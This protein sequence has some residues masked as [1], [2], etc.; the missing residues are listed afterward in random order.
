MAERTHKFYAPVAFGS[1]R[2]TIGH[3]FLTL[4]A[5]EF[6]AIL[7]DFNE[8]G[9]I[10]WGVEKPTIV[11]TDKQAIIQFFSGKAYNSK[12]LELLRPNS[13]VY[14]YFSSRPGN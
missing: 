6:L 4:Y 5:E 3:V 2:F 14:I 11:I 12:T 10:F 8:S 7:F 13:S 9:I 1:R